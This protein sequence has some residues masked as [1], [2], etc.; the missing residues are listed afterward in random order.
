MTKIQS[1]ACTQT[2]SVYICYVEATT[3]AIF[4]IV[5]PIGI[6]TAFA[7]WGTSNNY[8]CRLPPK[9]RSASFR[10]IIDCEDSQ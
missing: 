6:L 8:L 2:V 4:I 10:T 9:V 1:D 5:T 7:W 3:P